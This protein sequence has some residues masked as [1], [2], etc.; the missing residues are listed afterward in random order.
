MT[1]LH[2]LE[3][4]ADGNLV[5]KYETVGDGRDFWIDSYFDDM[6]SDQL[7]DCHQ[8]VQIHLGLMAH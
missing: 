1:N 7:S 2:Y 4:D 6:D 8:S 3:F 5:L